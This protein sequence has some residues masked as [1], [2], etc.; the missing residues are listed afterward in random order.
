V[1]ESTKEKHMLTGLIGTLVTVATGLID[2]L[3]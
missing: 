1:T 2:A 3:V